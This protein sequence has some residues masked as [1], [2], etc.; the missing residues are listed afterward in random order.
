[1]GS[2]WFVSLEWLQSLLRQGSWGFAAVRRNCTTER[3]QRGDKPGSVRARNRVRRSAAERNHPFAT[4]GPLASSLP[5]VNENVDLRRTM[6]DSV[7]RHLA[8]P[9]SGAVRRPLRRGAPL[10]TL[11][12]EERIKERIMTPEE[13]LQNRLDDQINWYRKRSQSNQSWFK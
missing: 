7:D 2:P 8:R 4:P 1:P 11:F 13:Y 12:E 3:L 5:A 6:S 9:A 10:G